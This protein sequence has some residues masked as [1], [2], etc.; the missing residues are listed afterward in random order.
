MSETMVKTQIE[1]PKAV[2][3]M[4]KLLK[5]EFDLTNKSK[6]VEFVVEAFRG[7]FKPEIEA[8]LAE[9]MTPEHAKLSAKRSRSVKELN[10][11]M[12]RW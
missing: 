6:A 1:L 4:L 8:E 2:D 11:E 10:E 12:D 5:V 7:E 3:R 9:A